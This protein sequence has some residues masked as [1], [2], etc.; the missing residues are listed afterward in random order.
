MLSRWECTFSITRQQMESTSYVWE[1]TYA[2]ETTLET[3]PRTKHLQGHSVE[4]A[5]PTYTKAS[6]DW[7]LTCFTMDH[8]GPSCLALPDC[9]D[10]APA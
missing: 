4:K 10:E 8:L 5:L 9:L 6:G 3:Y 1:P 7:K 2:F